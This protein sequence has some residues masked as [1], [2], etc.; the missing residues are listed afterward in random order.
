MLF[1][2]IKNLKKNGVRILSPISY[3][4]LS[5]ISYCYYATVLPYRIDIDLMSSVTISNRGFKLLSLGLPLIYSDLQNLINAQ[6]D[7]IWKCK[8]KEDFL[9][10]AKTLKNARPGPMI[11][12]FLSDHLEMNRKN[13]LTQILESII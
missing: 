13:Q 10:A 11:N 4:E 6:R 2:S 3:K 12:A 1:R 9:E 8:T 7:V 5:K